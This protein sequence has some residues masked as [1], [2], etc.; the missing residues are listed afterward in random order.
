VAHSK[1]FSESGTASSSVLIPVSWDFST[2]GKVLYASTMVKI[3]TP[4]ATGRN[5]QIGFVTATNYGVNDNSPQAFMTVIMQATVANAPTFDL[6]VQR[7]NTGGGIVETATLA[8]AVN[9]TVSNWYKMTVQ[10]INTRDDSVANNSSN[11]TATATVTDYGPQGIAPGAIVLGFTNATGLFS[12]IARSS[13]VFF[14]LRGQPNCGIDRRDDTY[15]WTT[16][17]NIFFVQEP[18]AQTV[19][20]GQHAMLAYKATC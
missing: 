6:R 3:K 8:P 16:Q 13:K 2:T 19:A 1:F 12:D 10:F 17:G 5:T 15:I 14:A 7:R 20:Q 4:T 18:Q 11:F 9:L